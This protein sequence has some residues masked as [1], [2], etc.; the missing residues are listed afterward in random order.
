MTADLASR[1]AVGAVG[2]PVVLGLAWLGGWWLFAGLLAAALVGLHEYVRL[3][4]PL[5]PLVLGAYVGAVLMLLGAQ[6]GGSAWVL[7][8]L[9][10][11]L[12][13]AFVLHGVSSTRASATAAIGSTLL[14]AGWIGLGLAHFV[15][16]RDLERGRLALLTALLAVWASDT[17]ALF[18]GR[19]IGRHK[20]APVISPGK[21]WEGFAAGTLAAVAVTFFALYEDR[22]DFVPIWQ[23]L[24]LGGAVA[25]AG[26]V[27][28]LFQSALKR[29]MQVKD[30]GRLLGAHGGVLDRIDSWLFAAP[31]A[32]YVLAA[33]GKA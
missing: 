24:V 6:L 23:A 12:G 18:V 17:L 28:D 15:L 32:F 26:V 3:V 31:A 14:G 33:F 7:G 29:D 20:L 8:A 10:A 16:L 13:V 21:T 27:G 19:L 2:V 30:T 1:V 25:L 11:T 22:D 9:V 4:R 5:R